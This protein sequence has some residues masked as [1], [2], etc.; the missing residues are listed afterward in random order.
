M[1]D[2]DL[3]LLSNPRISAEELARIAATRPDLHAQIAASPAAYPE[4]LEWLQTSNDPAVRAAL[5][6][7]QA[8]QSGGDAQGY[9]GTQETGDA[10]GKDNTKKWLW[11]AL[12]GALAV[13]LAG[14]GVWL[15]LGA[16]DEGTPEESTAAQSEVSEEVILEPEEQVEEEQ[17]EE[18]E[19]EEVK[20]E[21][22]N[23]DQIEAGNYSSVAGLWVN[24]QGDTLTFEGNEITRTFGDPYLQAFEE[25]REGYKDSY[26]CRILSLTREPGFLEIT[27][28]CHLPDQDGGVE[29]M[30][31]YRAGTPV[32]EWV[33]LGENAAPDLLPQLS[34]QDSDVPRILDASGGSDG[35]IAY[36]SDDIGQWIFYRPDQL[37]RK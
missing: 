7:R 37:P 31:F 12:V 22:I 36:P 6:A 29:F 4:L 28:T 32:T 5:A 26:I 13:I 34:S 9:A 19:E 10:Q 3:V 18:E 25:E 30:G 2:Q 20:P 14:V 33:F 23:L 27:Q 21:D 17:I 1:E 8:Q 24:G 16:K 35:M 11:P 15:W